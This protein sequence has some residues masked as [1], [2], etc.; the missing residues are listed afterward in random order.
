MSYSQY[1]SEVT[2]G[3]DRQPP[4]SC[5]ICCLSLNHQVCNLNTSLLLWMGCPPCCLPP[6]L[7]E[8]IPGHQT[9]SNICTLHRLPVEYLWCFTACRE[10][11]NEHALD[12]LP[13][14]PER[15]SLDV[16]RVSRCKSWTLVMVHHAAPICSGWSAA[17]LPLPATAS[18]CHK[19]LLHVTLITQREG[20]PR[21]KKET[22][23]RAIPAAKAPITSNTQHP[24]S[25]VLN[26]ECARQG[27]DLTIML[28]DCG[29]LY[30]IVCFV[31]TYWHGELL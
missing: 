29:V 3:K 15:R 8:V 20:S 12:L 30:G 6:P 16:K 10:D 4:Q 25:R 23:R 17:G 27:T 5:D 1:L 7:L 31:T 21:I 13:V 2:L 19:L 28:Y 22:P 24:P 14:S 11:V 18:C 26:D 9:H